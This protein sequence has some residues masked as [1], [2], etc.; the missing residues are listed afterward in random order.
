[1]ALRRQGHRD[2]AKLELENARKTL[3]QWTE[4]VFNTPEKFVP[5]AYWYD[6]PWFQRF[7][8]EAHTL[9]EGSP[10]AEDPRLVVVRGRAL[11]VLGRQGQADIEFDRAIRLAPDNARIRKAVEKAKNSGNHPR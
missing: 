8:R 11:S 2:E 5:V 10:P 4:Q 1:M 6:W 7:Y 9:I 3:E